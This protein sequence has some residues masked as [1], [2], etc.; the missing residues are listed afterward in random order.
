MDE[1]TYYQS[2]VE[3]LRREDEIKKHTYSKRTF[4]DLHQTAKQK[5]T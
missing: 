5:D 1:N 4:I 2:E 3:R